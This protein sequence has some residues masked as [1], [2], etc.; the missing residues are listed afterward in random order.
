MR[1]GVLAIAVTGLIYLLIVVAAIGL[2]GS[3]ETKL[4]IYP[5]LESARSAVVGEG[6]LERLDA[7]FIVLWVISVFTTLYS[8]YYLAACLLQQMFAF[9][10]QRMSSTLILPFTFIIAAFP[11]N[12]F[13][14]YSWSLAL[15]A[16]SM[17]I[18]SLYL[19]MLWSM[20]LIRRTRKRGAAR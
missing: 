13:E 18:L 5:T 19:F 1:A 4:M 2:F 9:R 11:A 7:I 12:V 20:Y 14:T 15:G 10:D 8:T 17:I 6:F 3:E 16:G